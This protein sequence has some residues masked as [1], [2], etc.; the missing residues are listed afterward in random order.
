M[1]TAGE[2]GID[3]TFGRAAVVLDALAEAQPSGLRFTDLMNR[4]GFS[5]ATL[6]RLLA[7]L[8]GSGL[9]DIDRASGLYFLGQ[10]LTA[11]ASRASRRHGLSEQIAVSVRVLS[12]RVEDTAYLSIRKHEMALC[13]ALQEGTAVIRAL[14]LNPGELSALGVGS[15][16]SAILAAIR[17]DAEIERIFA[18]PAHIAYCQARGI[19][20]EHIRKHLAR[21]RQ[22]GYAFVD[23]LNPEMIGI[24]MAIRDPA[25]DPVAAVSVAAI[26]SRFNDP[27]RREMVLAEMR[28][29]V[30]TLEA[31]FAQFPPTP[32]TTPFPQGG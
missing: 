29:S 12:E 8:S 31:V 26:H 23:D 20:Q 3:Q 18:T 2:K 19:P 5:K 1:V 27:A 28:G 21:A 25:G 16:S 30:K 13:L 6:H 4:T 24:G 10:R 11:W 17:D 14:P 22:L 32:R 7:G 9:T 15:A